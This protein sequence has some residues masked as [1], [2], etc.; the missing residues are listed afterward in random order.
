MSISLLD[1]QKRCYGLQLDGKLY[2]GT[3]VDLPCIVEAQKTLDYKTFFKSCDAAQMLY[4]H[5][6]FLEAVDQ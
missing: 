6:Y 2:L 5:N 3:L 4:I 1:Q